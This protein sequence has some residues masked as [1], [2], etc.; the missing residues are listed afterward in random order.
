MEHRKPLTAKKLWGIIRAI[1]YMMKKGLSKRFELHMLLKRT[2]KLAGKAIGSLLLEHQT[3]TCRS[4]NIH[5]TVI[6]PV[7]YEFSCS[8]TPLFY[9]KRKNNHNRHYHYKTTTVRRSYMDHDQLTVN[10][11]K[12]MFDFLNH[13]DDPEKSPLTVLGFGGSPNVRQLRVSDSPFPDNN[14]AE[15]S[16]QVDKAAEDFINNFYKEL[17]HQKKRAYLEP[18]SPEFYRTWGQVR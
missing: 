18:P 12:K 4:G 5:T 6:A 1:L 8:D 2:T 10:N 15:D 11:V 3:L 9:T 14:T 17:K 13:Y 7:E 16:F